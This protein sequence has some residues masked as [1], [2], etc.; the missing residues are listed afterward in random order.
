VALRSTPPATAVACA[1]QARSD[2]LQH[3]SQETDS[4]LTHE[5]VEI[6]LGHVLAGQRS[7]A[8]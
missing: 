2:L 5:L 3:L 1:A 7:P 8:L 6:G 4:E